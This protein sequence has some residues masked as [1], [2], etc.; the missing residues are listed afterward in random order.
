[1][2][3]KKSLLLLLAP[4]YLSGERLARE[5]LVYVMLLKTQYTKWWSVWSPLSGNFWAHLYFCLL[6]SGKRNV[7][8]GLCSKEL[9]GFVCS[10]QLFLPQGH[11]LLSTLQCLRVSISLIGKVTVWVLSQPLSLSLNF[12]NQIVAHKFNLQVFL[13]C[14]SS[15][16][17][18]AS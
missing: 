7:F 15:A 14:K 16:G 4:I 2:Y 10:D 17:A 6:K 12:E 13:Y 5:I 8:A 9:F 18:A 11:D 3:T 1:M